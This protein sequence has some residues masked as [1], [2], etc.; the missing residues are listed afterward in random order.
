MRARRDPGNLGRVWARQRA[1]VHQDPHAD[2]VVD[3]GEVATA[4]DHL[5][6]DA[7]VVLGT[8]G[9]DGLDLALL[10]DRDQLFL[11]DRGHRAAGVHQ[12]D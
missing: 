3:V 1:P 2:E 10:Q 12:A 4:N 6:V 11:V 8:P 5:L 7:V 9:D